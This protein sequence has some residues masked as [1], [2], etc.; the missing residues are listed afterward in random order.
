MSARAIQENIHPDAVTI[1]IKHS[2]VHTKTT[3]GQYSPVW[4]EQA[5]YRVCR[6]LTFLLYG[7]QAMLSKT[8]I[9]Q[10]KSVS[11]EMVCMVKS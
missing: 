4:C 5:T 7:T 11:M 6:L 10:L 2:Q 9:I 3:K 1:W 8:K